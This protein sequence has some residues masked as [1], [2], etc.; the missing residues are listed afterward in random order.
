MKLDYCGEFRVLTLREL[1]PGDLFSQVL[2]TPEK[3][4][5]GIGRMWPAMCGTTRISSNCTL[6]P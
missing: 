4:R 1:P 2:D 3:R 5:L 6:F